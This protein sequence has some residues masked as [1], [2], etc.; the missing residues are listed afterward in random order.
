MRRARRSAGLV[1]LS[2]PGTVSA[3]ESCGPEA[4]IFVKSRSSSLALRDDG[5]DFGRVVP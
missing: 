5:L 1:Q 4:G 3:A 2:V